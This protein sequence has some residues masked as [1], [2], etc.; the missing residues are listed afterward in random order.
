M[1][2]Q[3]LPGSSGAAAEAEDRLNQ[4]E[5]IWSGP[6]LD[7][8]AP[9]SSEALLGPAGAAYKHNLNGILVATD[10][11]LKICCAMG[12]TFFSQRRAPARKQ[13][14]C[15]WSVLFHVSGTD[16]HGPPRGCQG[17]PT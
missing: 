17:M 15:L 7:L 11:L 14:G 6:S 2:G 13:R 1:I 3:A 12:A 16:W 5:S 8:T 10:G 9:F 4:L